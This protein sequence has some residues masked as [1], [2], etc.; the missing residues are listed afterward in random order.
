MVS[1][2]FC[3]ND[4][5]TENRISLQMIRRMYDFLGNLRSGKRE[6]TGRQKDWVTDRRMRWKRERRRRED[7]ARGS[8]INRE[9]RATGSRN[10]AAHLL[11]LSLSSS[12]PLPLPTPPSP[13][14][15]PPPPPFSSFSL[16]S[17]RVRK[18]ESGRLIYKRR[19]KARLR[20]AVRG[21]HSRTRPRSSHASRCITCAHFA[22]LHPDVMR[23]AAHLFKNPCLHTLL[24][25]QYATPTFSA[26]LAP[27]A[28]HARVTSYR[29]HDTLMCIYIGDIR[30]FSRSF[31]LE[32]IMA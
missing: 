2:P 18:R 24:F 3:S 20:R 7:R 11:L 19:D 6:V 21:S 8:S 13:L 25:K 1:R 9:T 16:L 12:L 28:P 31:I 29:V 4:W 17:H 27:R 10:W 30:I 5:K 14:S 26:T 32:I 15:S 23:Q 22:R